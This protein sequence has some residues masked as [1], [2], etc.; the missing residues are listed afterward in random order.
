MAISRRFSSGIDNRFSGISKPAIPFPE[1][2]IAW[3]RFNEGGGDTVYNRALNGSKGGG[4]LPNLT[5][6][7]TAGSFWSGYGIGGSAYTGAQTNPSYAWKKLSSARTFGGSAN[8]YDC[9][10]IF[11]R[12]TFDD[13]AGGIFCKASQVNGVGSGFSDMYESAYYFPNDQALRHG[14]DGQAEGYRPYEDLKKW[15]FIFTASDRKFR[16]V[17]NDGILW[18]GSVAFGMSTAL[19][20]LYIYAGVGYSSPEGGQGFGG[21]RACYAEWII[22]NFKMLTQAQWAIWYDLLRGRFGMPKRSGW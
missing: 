3:Y 1:Y 17:K 2:L 16:V 15:W 13:N 11:V 22:Y 14:Y 20:L 9:M 6:V 21:C 4:L 5:V 12:P 18:T 10:G 8:G 19:N 7:N